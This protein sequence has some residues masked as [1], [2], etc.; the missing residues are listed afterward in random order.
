MTERP[1]YRQVLG[2]LNAIRYRLIPKGYEN[3][4]RFE[5]EPSTCFTAGDLIRLAAEVL[6][7]K[8]DEKVYVDELPPV[9][10]K[11]LKELHPD[12]VW[13]KTYN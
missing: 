9:V 11:N 13:E 6:A 3:V 10:L 4:E 7:E 8:V 2:R 1:D 12:R 5:L